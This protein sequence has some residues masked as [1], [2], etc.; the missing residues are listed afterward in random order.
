MPSAGGPRHPRTRRRALLPASAVVVAVLV[1]AAAGAILL[2]SHQPRRDH[3]MTSLT[4]CAARRTASLQAELTGPVPS[5]LRGNV[6]PLGVSG[7]GKAVYVATE[8]S[9]FAGI[10]AVTVASGNLRKIQV[11]RHPADDEAF[12]SSDGRW[13]VWAEV[14]NFQ[15]MARGNGNG[16]ADVTVHSWDSVTGQMRTLGHAREPLIGVPVVSGHHAAWGQGSGI[17]LANLLS[18][19]ATVIGR[20]DPEVFFDGSLVV[21]PGLGS[22]PRNAA[23]TMHAF[24]VISGRPARLPLALKSAGGAVMV[25]SDGVRTAYVSRNLRSL[26]YSPAEDQAAHAIMHGTLLAGGVALGP[27]WLGWTDFQGV[28]Y[29]ASTRTGA[30]LVA[31]QADGGALGPGPSLVVQDFLGLP[32]AHALQY[33]PSVIRVIGNPAWPACHGT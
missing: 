9:G 23:T 27:G 7:D 6:E 3:V 1:G 4:L 8:T 11:F 28:S 18:G 5:T 25:V 13:L 15:Q 31:T 14:T 12:G 22:G 10:A 17:V 16:P 30:Y 33:Q 26:Y 20:G 21:W 2:V 29:L 19:H 32:T 24:S